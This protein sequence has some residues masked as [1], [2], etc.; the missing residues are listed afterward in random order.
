MGVVLRIELGQGS[1]YSSS[2]TTCHYSFIQSTQLDINLVITLQPIH[3]YTDKIYSSLSMGY[4]YLT[5]FMLVKKISH[6]YRDSVHDI[7]FN[8]LILHDEFS[9]LSS[10]ISLCV[11]IIGSLYFNLDCVFS[12]TFQFSYNIFQHAQLLRVAY[13]T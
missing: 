12:L 7:Q 5:Q 9:N 11:F 3:L 6:S 4:V 1:V 8:L 2:K 13:L 10:L